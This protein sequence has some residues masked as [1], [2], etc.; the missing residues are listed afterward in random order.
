MPH[1]SAFTK[2]ICRFLIHRYMGDYLLTELTTNQLEV[3]LADGKALVQNV[4]LNTEVRITLK[5]FFKS[6]I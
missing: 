1:L 6:L 2:P 3:S 4:N 5:F